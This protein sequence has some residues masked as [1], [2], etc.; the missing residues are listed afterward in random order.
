MLTRRMDV[1][2]MRFILS[3]WEVGQMPVKPIPVKMERCSYF[4]LYFGDEKTTPT[5]PQWNGRMWYSLRYPT[6]TSKSL[7]NFRWIIVKFRE[8]LGRWGV[9]LSTRVF[10]WHAQGFEFNLYVA[11]HTQALMH[12]RTRA[13][14]HSEIDRDRRRQRQRVKKIFWALNL[15]E[16]Y[17][18]Y[19]IDF[20]LE[21]FL[22]SVY[23]WT[24]KWLGYFI[25][26]VSGILISSGSSI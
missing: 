22:H 26:S 17:A 2:V 7:G 1:N 10:A 24:M 8:M 23:I 13:H 20:A 3:S 6:H 25:S 14:M 19:E 9:W 15:W 11:T 18:F 12:A 21:Y 4:S 5:H 16:N